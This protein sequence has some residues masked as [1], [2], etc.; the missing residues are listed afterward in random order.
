MINLPVCFNVDDIRGFFTDSYENGDFVVDK[1]G[2]K[3]L[4][5][6]GACFLATESI[7]FGSVNEDYVQ[8]E[9]DWYVS[10]SLNVYDIPGGPPKIWE[11]VA[12][13]NPPGL[14]NSNYGWAIFS[15]D[16]GKQ[17]DNVLKELKAN[18]W[19]RRAVMI[20]TRP[21]MHTDYN[22]GGMSDFMCT[23]T[24]QYMIRND[25]LQ[26]IVQ[27]R[28]ND[29]WA[30][31]RNDYAWQKYVLDNLA[32]D[33]NIEAGAIVWNAGS[34]HCYEKDFYLVDHYSR[35]DEIAITKKEYRELYPE[36]ECA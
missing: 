5:M 11:Q 13:K 27:M 1:S 21:T 30:G 28:S 32:R 9:L 2:V 17:Y 33:L 18:P 15:E 31:Y 35:T 7:I 26:A 8:R 4:E 20:Y 3:M 29:I 22:F 19:S 24:V 34:L 23:N 36:S 10:Q 16:N 6:V 25:K 12:S 14:I